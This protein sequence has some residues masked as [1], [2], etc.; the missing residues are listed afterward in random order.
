MVI[1]SDERV[2][3]KAVVS[4]RRLVLLRHLVVFRYNFLLPT[5]HLEVLLVEFAHEPMVHLAACVIVASL[6]GLVFA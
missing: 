6:I 4:D 5:Q 2:T 1:A 3:I